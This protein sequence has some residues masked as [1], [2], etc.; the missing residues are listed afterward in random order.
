MPS[1]TERIINIVST[2][3]DLPASLTD[4]L[5]GGNTI[6]DS[7]SAENIGCIEDNKPG[8]VLKNQ[9]LNLISIIS[10]LQGNLEHLKAEHIKKS[11]Q[12]DLSYEQINTNTQITVI[13]LIRAFAFLHFR[14]GIRKINEVPYK[15][16]IIP[17]AYYLGTGDNWNNRSILAKLEYWYW[18]SIFGGAYRYE[19]NDRVIR[20]MKALASWLNDGESFLDSAYN[21]IFN[22]PGYSNK[23]VLLMQDPDNEVPG[24]IRDALLQYILSRQPLD[25]LPGEPIRLNTWDIA[26]RKECQ[27]KEETLI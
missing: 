26:S 5:I 9:F 10:H 7:W 18:T 3:I 22:F 2:P 27:Y 20:D 21:G 1:L 6:P 8:T 12:L 14:C 15:L 16:M 19:Q 24:S 13:S 23:E 11:K 25:F 4:I 17:I